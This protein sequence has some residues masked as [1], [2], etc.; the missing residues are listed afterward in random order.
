M[1]RVMIPWVLVCSIGCGVVNGDVAG[2][3]AATDGDDQPDSD[4][5][6]DDSDDDDPFDTDNPDDPDDPDGHESLTI[7]VDAMLGHLD[8]LQDIADAHGGNRSAGTTGFDASVDYVTAQL[9]D[10][11]Y[12]VSLHEFEVMDETINAPSELRVLEP[13]AVELEYG[14]DFINLSFSGSGDVTGRIVPVDLVIPPGDHPNTS[15]SGC[16]AADFGGFPSGAVALVQRGT[17]VFQDKVDNAVAAG[18]VA[19]LVF[20]EGQP[21]R[22]GL[23]GGTLSEDSPED[24]PALALTYEVGGQLAVLAGESAVDVQVVTD[25]TREQI[26]TVNTIVDT[27]G[28]TEDVI[29]VG[30]HLDSVTAGPGINDNGSGVGLVLELA[31][32]LAASGESTNHRIRFVFWG[33]E[34]LGLL[35]SLAYIREIDDAAHS[36]ILSNLNFDMIA[37][38]NPVP[39]VYDGDGS[40]MGDAGPSG[41]DAIEDLFLQWF[42]DHDIASQ[43]TAFD[44]RS[45]YGPFIW[46]GIPAGGLFTGAEA[47]MSA[48]QAALY[49]GT[50]G[51]AYDACYHQSCDTRDNIDPSVYDAMGNAAASVMMSLADQQGGLG[52]LGP[53]IL[54]SRPD[55]PVMPVTIGG[56]HTPIRVD[57]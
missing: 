14:E 16:E 25:V 11:G 7:D 44:G 6:G 41:S 29:V 52:A 40:D 28:A 48:S 53:P 49:N 54:D 4:P 33:A 35:G 34:E 37:S 12:S 1:H 47:Q 18:A 17:C 2:T 20:N 15:T 50:A 13:A 45:D 51:E 21:D 36:A 56:C 46:T 57:R 8:A 9:V 26:P 30:A 32:A 22:Q 27:E 55:L 3:D 38:P 5:T 42:A 10:V 24:V 31:R 23:F 19:V 39:F 43:P